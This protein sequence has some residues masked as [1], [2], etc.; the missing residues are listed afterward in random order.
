MHN[1]VPCLTLNNRKVIHISDLMMIMR[2][3]TNILTVIKREMDKLRTHGPIIHFSTLQWRHNERDDVS[4]HRRLDG[5]LNR[6]FRRKSRKTSKLR[7]PGLCE[8]N[9]PMTGEFPS[10]RASY[11]ENVSIWWRHHDCISFMFASHALG[12]SHL[13]Q[14]WRTS[15][16]P[17]EN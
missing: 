11:A 4:N 10:Q 5:L 2:W 15:I 17:A 14:Y 13:M 7:A 12:Q 6:L 8:G 3:S 9:S 1:I 16:K